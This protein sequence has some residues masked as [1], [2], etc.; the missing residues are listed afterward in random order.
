MILMNINTYDLFG[1]SLHPARTQVEAQREKKKKYARMARQRAPGPKGEEEEEVDKPKYVDRC[2]ECMCE[3]LACPKAPAI[4]L[5]HAPALPRA[6]GRGAP[7][8]PRHG[9][10]SHRRG[11]HF[12]GCGSLLIAPG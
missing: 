3:F 8:G 10:G 11:G 9:P 6:Q 1:S 12:E 5:R 4:Y 2:A 7:E